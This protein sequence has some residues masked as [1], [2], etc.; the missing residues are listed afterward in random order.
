MPLFNFQLVPEHDVQP[1]EIRK[2]QKRFHWY[3]MSRGRFW[4]D[5]GTTQLFA[6]TEFYVA[7]FWE[8]LLDALALKPGERIRV[9]LRFLPHPPAVELRRE[10]EWL[11][12][13]VDGEDYKIAF[14]EFAAAVREFHLRFFDAMKSRIAHLI[15]EDAAAFEAE[16]RRRFAWLPQ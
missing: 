13:R 4:V 14:E 8:A 3:S 9:N 2:G 1:W 5:L 15:P 6:D 11:Y 16:H 12:M 10:G 7:Q